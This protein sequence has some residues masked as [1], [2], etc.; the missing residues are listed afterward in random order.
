M[1]LN[2]EKE[3]AY[4]ARRYQIKLD[5]RRFWQGLTAVVVIWFAGPYLLRAIARAFPSF[6][7]TM[8]QLTERM[9]L[10]DN[11]VNPKNRNADPSRSLPELP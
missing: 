3:F 8:I 6:P 10:S 5:D 9:D 4:Y 11:P 1:K 7:D 2:L